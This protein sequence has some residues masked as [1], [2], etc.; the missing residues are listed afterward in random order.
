MKKLQIKKVTSKNELEQVLQIRKK[1]FIEE[2][3]V[4]VEIEMDEFDETAEHFI[5]YL[6]K[7]PVGCGRIRYN[8]DFAKLE[9]IAITKNHRKKGYG[10]QLTNYLIQYCKEK[11]IRKIVI[12]SQRYVLDFYRRFGFKIVGE[13]FDEAGI[14]HVKMI[15]GL[16]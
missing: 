15:L 4:P 3:K 12:H 10:T 14:K 6:D 16:S 7:E 13:P 5:A 9:R 11:K 8:N 2:Q 1:V